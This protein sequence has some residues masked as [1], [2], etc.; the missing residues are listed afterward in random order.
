MAQFLDLTKH[1]ASY[2]NPYAIALTGDCPMD[3]RAAAR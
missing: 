2:G 1:A 3:C